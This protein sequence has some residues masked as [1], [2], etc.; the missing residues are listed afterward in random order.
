MRLLVEKGMRINDYQGVLGRDGH[1]YVADPLQLQAIGKKVNR[2]LLEG[3]YMSSTSPE[4]ENRPKK[5][6]LADG[7]GL[8][9]WRCGTG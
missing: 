2:H 9:P 5:A 8:P 6:A 3:V 1:F 4:R 7:L